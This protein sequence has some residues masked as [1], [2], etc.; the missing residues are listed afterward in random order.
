[1]RKILYVLPMIVIGILVILVAHWTPTRS[2]RLDEPEFPGGNVTIFP[3]KVKVGTT[4]NW[5]IEI[6]LG[7]KGLAKGGKLLVRYLHYSFA[8]HPPIQLY[9]GDKPNEPGFVEAF[10]DHGQCTA[11]VEKIEYGR[12]AIFVTNSGAALLNG[13]KIAVQINNIEAPRISEERFTFLVLADSDGDGLYGR[14]KEVGTVVVEPGEPRGIACFAQSLVRPG[15]SPEISCRIE[16]M[17]RNLTS[18]FENP[19]IVTMVNEYK[20]LEVQGNGRPTVTFKGPVVTVEGPGEVEVSTNVGDENF[21][22]FTNPIMVETRRDGKMLLWGD[23]HGH[24]ALSDGRGTPS[25]YYKYARD[26]SFLDVAS[27]SDH[28]WQMTADEFN[29]LF[30]TTEKFNEPGRFVTIPSAEINI[31]GHEVAYFFDATKVKKIRIGRRGGAQEFWHELFAG[32]DE[33]EFLMTYEKMISVYGDE[34][35]VIVP[36]TTLS[37]DM[38]SPLDKPVPRQLAIEVFSSHGSSE[39]VGCPFQIS[40]GGNECSSVRQELNR[41]TIMG[42]IASG[43]SHDGRPGNS[44]FSAYDGGLVAFYVDQFNRQGVYEALKNR[45]VYATNGCRAVLDFSINGHPMGDQFSSKEPRRI[46]YRIIAGPETGSVRIIKNGEEFHINDQYTF[47]SWVEFIDEDPSPSYYYLR[48][49]TSGGQ[50]VV[51]SSPIWVRH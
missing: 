19:L 49:S 43:D 7:P 29:H 25:N 14:I 18:S 40:T 9:Q 16:D 38:G 30:M 51:W 24:S 4:V 31:R 33:G 48:G 42:I 6:T 20:T 27:L 2:L 50:C 28:D 45:H 10:C 21:R 32:M 37:K 23:I 5:R 46:R 47:G 15:N 1:M 35:L 22:T 26:V 8:S 44:I 17:W 3:D 36:H 11:K 41:G 34:G 12:V 13:E 39:C